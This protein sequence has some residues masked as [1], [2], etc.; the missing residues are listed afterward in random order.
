MHK[1]S[2]KRAFGLLSSLTLCAPAFAAPVITGTQGAAG[3]GQTITV[4]G[5]GFGNGPKVLIFDDF[6]SGNGAVGGAIPTTSPKVG[7][8]TQYGHQTG[9]PRYSSYAN[10]GTHAWRLSDPAFDPN[11]DNG[12]RVGQFL[13]LFSSPI[14]EV[15]IAFQAAVP[16]NTTFPG[17]S[18]P[19][20]FPSVSSW[21]FSWVYDGDMGFGGD[22]RADMCLPTQVGGGQ[23]WYAGNDGNLADLGNA[24]WTWNGFNHMSM[25]LRAN[26]SNPSSSGNTYFQAV[27]A[28]KG[29]TQKSWSDRSVFPESGGTKS[30]DRMTVPGWW[31]N[32]DNTKNQAT[33]DDV[34]VATG[35]NAAARIEI[36]DAP[37]YS[38]VHNITILTPTSWNG[39]QITATVRAG[40]FKSFSNAYLFVVDSNNNVSA[41]FPVCTSCAV[42]PMPPTDVEVN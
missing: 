13:Q 25:W 36:G 18:S 22:N 2:G 35:P 33:Y 40:S 29:M 26:T 19:R 21:K 32:G 38:Q 34:Y 20:T 5:T 4:S 17:A 1:L 12:N 10:S 39:S 14:T 6:E 23:F 16:P 15:F 42:M 27:N 37:V 28:E 9:R 31:G 41:G 11:I 24:W 7:Q 8:W 3:D 30:W